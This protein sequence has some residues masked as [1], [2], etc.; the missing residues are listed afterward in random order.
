[1]PNPYTD[2]PELSLPELSLAELKARYYR[3]W[4]VKV[5]WKRDHDIAVDSGIK[6]G[7]VTLFWY[8]WSD[9]RLRVSL[10]TAWT[11]GQ[12]HIVYGGPL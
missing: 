11:F 10:S 9:G 12:E 6:L 3:W 5:F 1:M 2:E 4:T 8:R 7:P